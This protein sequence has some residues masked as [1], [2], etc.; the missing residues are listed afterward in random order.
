MSLPVEDRVEIR[1]Q[2]RNLENFLDYDFSDQK[3]LSLIED[4]VHGH[5]IEILKDIDTQHL[6]WKNYSIIWWNDSLSVRKISEY[7]TNTV[8]VWEQSVQNDAQKLVLLE[9]QCALFEKLVAKHNQNQEG[10]ETTEK[11]VSFVNP[12][13]KV[14]SVV[15][16]YPV[17][18][19]Q[20][21]K[22]NVTQDVQYD[23]LTSAAELATLVEEA[24]NKPV[25]VQILGSASVEK[26]DKVAIPFT[27][28]P[29]D[30]FKSVTQYPKELFDPTDGQLRERHQI[31]QVFYDD[32]DLSVLYNALFKAG[33]NQAL[34]HV[35]EQGFIE[36][37]IAGHHET[38]QKIQEIFSGKASG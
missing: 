22:V 9:K 31:I 8:P 32:P 36:G 17:L 18:I 13:K 15:S 2:A 6:D 4:K 1:R 37:K 30:L 5:A 38:I 16:N 29:K 25:L 27:V 28:V 33:E 7:I 24:K 20:S 23:R 11:P 12:F 35:Y 19:G 14:L 34:S 21:L 10:S 3:K 26:S